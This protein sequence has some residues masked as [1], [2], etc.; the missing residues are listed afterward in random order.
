MIGMNRFN[1]YFL[2]GIVM[3]FLIISP[4][5]IFAH[6][7]SLDFTTMSGTDLGFLY[8]KLGFTHIIPFGY[9]H[10]LFVIGL[11]LLNPKLKTVI[12]QATAFT[13]AHSLT[14]GLAMFGMIHP[15]S[16]IIEPI[17]ALSIFF[18]AVENIFLNDVKWWRILIVFCFGLIHGCGFA[19]ALKEIGLPASDYGLALFSFNVGVE[20]GQISVIL[21]AWLL[22]GKWFSGK[23][24]YKNRIVIPISC[25]I[26]VLSLYWTVE[27]IFFAA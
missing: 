3:M 23:T 15:V 24:W 26:A 6:A 18:I 16:S 8:L 10:V 22:V 17:I 27:R 7:L 2:A 19:S 12:G 13:I 14:L 11:F 1:K 25:C 5:H 4:Q 21:F 9:D 20:L